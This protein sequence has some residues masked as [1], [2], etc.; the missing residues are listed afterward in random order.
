M[1]HCNM[2]LM[3]KYLEYFKYTGLVPCCLCSFLCLNISIMTPLLQ[4]L[5][6]AIIWFCLPWFG[7]LVTTSC[8][9]SPLGVV[10]WNGYKTF[11]RALCVTF[12]QDFLVLTAFTVL[13][14]FK[15][16]SI[17]SIQSKAYLHCGSNYNLERHKTK[18]KR[19]SKPTLHSLI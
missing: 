16:T 17:S 12:C 14:Y 18:Q 4:W 1:Q 7:V 15:W 10:D 8:W 11:R 19:I 6:D 2:N 5:G 3:V 9:F 13:Q